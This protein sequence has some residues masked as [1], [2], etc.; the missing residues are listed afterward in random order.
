MPQTF[1]MSHIGCLM[2]AFNP[3]LPNTWTLAF[4][5]PNNWTLTCNIPNIWTLN[6]LAQNN[7]T[8]T[9]LAPNNWILIW[10]ILNIYTL[11]YW[12][13]N[14]WMST[15]LKRIDKLIWPQ[16]IHFCFGTFQIFGVRIFR[17]WIIGVWLGTSQI[18]RL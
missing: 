15:S 16:I 3:R 17:L 8:L 2:I 14:I 6:F 4:W 1:G 12:A 18:L 7:W 11:T 10:N 13:S 9:H 5:A